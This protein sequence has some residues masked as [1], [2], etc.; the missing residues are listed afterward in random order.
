MHQHY[1]CN[2][3]CYKTDLDSTAGEILRIQLSLKTPFTQSNLS[4]FLLNLY[5]LSGV[6]YKALGV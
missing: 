6:I 5:R 2:K 3:Q 1:N 4:F